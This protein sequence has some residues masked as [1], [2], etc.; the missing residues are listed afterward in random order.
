MLF[1]KVDHG[2]TGVITNFGFSDLY[3]KHNLAVVNAVVLFLEL[4]ILNVLQES[5]QGE[6]VIVMA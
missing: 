5:W 4:T 1:S 3:L 2:F 6:T